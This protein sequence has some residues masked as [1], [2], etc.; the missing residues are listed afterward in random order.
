MYNLERINGCPRRA[1]SERILID[2]RMEVTSLSK[3]N[4]ESS[5]HLQLDS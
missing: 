2:R 1:K 4:L 3:K 5:Q